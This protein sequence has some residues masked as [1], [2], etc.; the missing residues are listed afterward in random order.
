MRSK[1]AVVALCSVNGAVAPDP[2]QRPK[3]IWAMILQDHP[4]WGSTFTTS[5]AELKQKATDFFEQADDKT[6]QEYQNRYDSEM[7]EYTQK[8]EQHKQR[9]R[10]SKKKKAR[11]ALAFFHEHAHQKYLDKGLDEKEVLNKVAEEWKEMSKTQR[12]PY[13]E[14]RNEEIKR[15]RAAPREEVQEVLVSS[16]QG[17]VVRLLVACIPLGKRTGQGKVIM[18]PGKGDS[19]SSASVISSRDHQQDEEDGDDVDNA[20]DNAPEDNKEADSKAFVRR[21]S[22]SLSCELEEHK[23]AQL[24]EKKKSCCT[25]GANSFCSCTAHS[26]R[27]LWSC[28]TSARHAPRWVQE[29]DDRGDSVYPPSYVVCCSL[30]VSGFTWATAIEAAHHS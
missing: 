2:P 10:S 11:T 13:D 20:V 3:E 25:K 29:D 6:K 7:A 5:Y 30:E 9:L 21:L 15:I 22:L 28:Q 18:K 23:Q 8:M 12:E 19:V 26:A 17:N 4:D 27:R 1:E 24:E 14:M 16:E